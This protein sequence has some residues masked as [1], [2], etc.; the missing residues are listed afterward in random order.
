[1]SEGCLRRMSDKRLQ[2][3][4]RDFSPQLPQWQVLRQRMSDMLALR[5]VQLLKGMK[6]QAV[7]GRDAVMHS[8]WRKGSLWV[9]LASDAGNALVRQVSD[10]VEKRKESSAS[11]VSTVLYSPFD[12]ATLGAALGRKKISVVA[13]SGGIPVEKLQQLT[14][15]HQAI[16]K[17]MTEVKQKES[18]VTNGE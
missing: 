15:W 1:M 10:A 5:V 6:R 17:T 7:I 18:K 3:L 2:V 16:V 8:M 11:S 12:A 4:N 9:L 14:V 13:F